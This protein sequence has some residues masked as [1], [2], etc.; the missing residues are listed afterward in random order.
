[1]L[2]PCAA[3]AQLSDTCEQYYCNANLSYDGYGNV[4]GWVAYYDDGQGWYMGID[5][6]VDGPGPE[7]TSS[8]VEDPGYDDGLTSCTAEIGGNG[9]WTITGNPWY[10]VEDWHPWYYVEDWQ[11]PDGGSVSY[12]VTAVEAP[13]GESIAPLQSIGGGWV[14]EVFLNTLEPTSFDFDGFTLAEVLSNP[15]DTCYL[16]WSQGP[17]SPKGVLPVG[18]PIT[19]NGPYTDSIGADPNWVS[20]YQGLLD[21]TGSSCEWSFNQEMDYAGQEFVYNTDGVGVAY[22]DYWTFRGVDGACSVDGPSGSST[23]CD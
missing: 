10:Y 14:G 18:Q 4:V 16:Y 15:I 23:G 20:Y 9:V 6:E 2:V 22:G 11:E 21:G 1:M 7:P 8:C 3:H 17:D 13:F 19:V 12:G 5:A